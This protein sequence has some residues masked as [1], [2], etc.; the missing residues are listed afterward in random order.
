MSVREITIRLLR[1]TDS[2]EELTDLLHRAYARLAEMGFRY[3]ATHQ[4]PEVTKERCAAG[5]TYVAEQNGKLV[6]TITVR[7]TAGPQDRNT[8][9]PAHYVRPD[10]MIF[11]QFAVDPALQNTGLGSQL[12]QTVENRARELKANELACDTAEGATHL[13]DYYTKRGYRKVD[14]VKWETVNYRSVILS[15]HLTD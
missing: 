4:T 1:E 5:E 9:T 11:G 12:L 8:V 3:Y 14:D 10:V 2:M 15:K 6:G 7:R 13:I